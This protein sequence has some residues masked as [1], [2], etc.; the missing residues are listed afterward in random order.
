MTQITARKTI[1][2]P[3]VTQSG[4]KLGKVRDLVFDLDTQV[5]N[6]YIV[7]KRLEKHPRFIAPKQVISIS[8][9]CMVV[10]DTTISDQKAVETE[11]PQSVSV[12]A[13]PR[14]I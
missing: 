10:E 3:T 6:F 9:D 7:A 8:A 5:L 14:S 2:L 1:G 11:L 13:S 4:I 12:G